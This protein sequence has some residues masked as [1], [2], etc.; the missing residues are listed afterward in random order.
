MTFRKSRRG[1]KNF[2]H[3]IPAESPVQD[4]G[5][6]KG[7]TV[8]SSIFIDDKPYPYH[9]LII[10][11]LDISVLGNVYLLGGIIT[12][13]L[14]E[15]IMPKFDKKKY[16]KKNILLLYLEI[17]IY[18]AC[19]MITAFFLRKIINLGHFRFFGCPSGPGTCV[20]EVH[21]GYDRRR[22]SESRGGAIIAF[23][24][25]IFHTQFKKKLKYLVNNR[26]LPYFLPKNSVLF[27][28]E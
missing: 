1:I 22:V 3:V 19:I 15:Y 28:P 18:T 23:A 27:A 12:A 8:I 7:E 4:Y 6:K 21:C 16:D 2:H 11:L 26:I 10:R 13:L 5:I 14:I 9:R 20:P 24:I 17:V 25:I